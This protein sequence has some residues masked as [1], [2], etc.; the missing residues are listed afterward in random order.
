MSK[1]ETAMQNKLTT[2][3]GA[4]TLVTPDPSGKTSGRISLYFKSTRTLNIPQLYRYLKV[5]SSEDPVHTL[6]LVFY[7]RDCR[8]VGKAERELGRQALK[9]MFLNFPELFMKVAHLIPM[10]GRWDDLLHLWPCILDL[11]CP[12]QNPTD[13]QMTRWLQYLRNNYCSRI[14]DK[15]TLFKLQRYQKDLVRLVGNQLVKDKKEMEGGN[16][17]SLCAKWAPTERGSLDQQYGVTGTLCRIMGWSRTKYRKEFTSPLRSYLEVVESLM[18]RKDW[19]KIDFN[20]VPSCA[21]KRLKKAFEKHTPATFYEWRNRLVTGQTK[22]NAKELQPHELIHEIRTKSKT[23][24][25]I[26]AQWMVLEQEIRKLGVLTDSVVVVDTSSS[27]TSWGG[28]QK[29]SFSPLDV[30]IGIGILIASSVKGPFHNNII[31]F[32]QSPTF[33]KLKRN[34][35]YQRYVQICNAS[36]AGNTNLQATFD[37]ILECAQESKLTD[38]DMPKRIFILSDMQFDSADVITKNDDFDLTHHRTNFHAIDAKYKAAGYIRPQIIFWDVCGE[39]EDFAVSVNEQG[40][41]LVS[42]FSPSII[43]AIL[44]GDKLDP[45]SMVLKTLGDERYES[46]WK[47]LE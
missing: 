43:K 29:Y 24:N 6:I 10:Y 47:A 33:V 46:L 38:D 40:T 32:S 39:G 9:W 45:W 1:F 2:W 31:T 25:V 19:E 42:G 22:V 11:K 7:I 18:C 17:V 21:M 8:G 12:T 26:E 15:E 27:M 34:T 23:D 44:H 36:W 16:T 35:L 14:S 3:N 41:A 13:A 4:K 37:L 20:R 5:A 30:A 28:K